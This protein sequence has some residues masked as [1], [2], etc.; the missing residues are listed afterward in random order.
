MALLI[1]LLNKLVFLQD[2]LIDMSY[3]IVV[4]AEEQFVGAVKR[5]TVSFLV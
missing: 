5:N 1:K 2:L 4:I 3:L